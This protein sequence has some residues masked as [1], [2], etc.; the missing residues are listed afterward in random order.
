LQAVLAVRVAEDSESLAYKGVMRASEG[1]PLREVL[2]VGSVWR[3]PLTRSLTNGC[4]SSCSIA[5]PTD[6][7]SG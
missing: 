3:C 7:Y 2:T 5:S 4:S 1:D 6:G